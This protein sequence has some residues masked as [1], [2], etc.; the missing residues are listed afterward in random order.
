MHKQVSSIAGL[1]LV[2][3]GGGGKGRF[4]ESGGGQQC[5]DPCVHLG[6]GTCSPE[7]FVF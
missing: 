7:M 3:G 1:H 2:G 4:Y 5:K 6:L